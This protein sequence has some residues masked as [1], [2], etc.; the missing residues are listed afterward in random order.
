MLHLTTVEN[1]TYSL[2]QKLFT[3][4]FI[5]NNFALAGGTSLSLQIGHRKSI[6][7]DFFSPIQFD[8][9]EL[10]TILSTNKDLTYTFIG[11]N[12]RMFFCYL[13]EVKCDFVQEPAKLLNPFLEIEKV[14]YFSV[15]D[16]AAMK[17]HT[18][19]GRGKRKD[20]FDLFALL[21]IYDWKSLLKI[22]ERKYSQDQFYILWKSIRY[23]DDAD[24]DPIIRGYKPYD[25]SWEEIKEIILQKCK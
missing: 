21:Q 18:I 2:L 19:C 12:S 15:E 20:F 17:M 1:S 8:L 4:P 5:Q 24:A 3:I 25:K 22:F 9:L 23:F 14:L 11:K 10:E 6:D 13:N 7:L 16:I